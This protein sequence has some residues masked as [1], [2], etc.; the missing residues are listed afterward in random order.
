[1]TYKQFLDWCVVFDSKV[2]KE[3][4]YQQIIVSSNQEVKFKI[5]PDKVNIMIPKKNWR[6]LDK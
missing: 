3:S 6:N 2:F 4:N 1:M 5:I